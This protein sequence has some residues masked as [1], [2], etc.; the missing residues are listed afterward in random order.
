MNKESSK[1]EQ[2]IDK[3]IES[4][5]QSKLEF[6]TLDILYSQYNKQHAPIELYDMVLDLYN[7]Y[8]NNGVEKTISK[9]SALKEISF[10]VI[11]DYTKREESKQE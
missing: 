5:I 7:T 11:D 4:S 2:K 8:L 10:S 3:L 6:Y 1:I 9:Y